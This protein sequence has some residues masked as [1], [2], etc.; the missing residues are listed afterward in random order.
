MRMKKGVLAVFLAAIFFNSTSIKAQ[1][2]IRAMS[3]NTLDFPGVASS[4]ADTLKKIIDYVLPDI[5]MAC[6]IQSQTGVNLIMSNALNTSG[7]NYYAQAPFINGPDTDNML[8]Y[9]S[10]KLGLKSNHRIATSLRDINEYVLY[11][12][13][14]DIATTNDTIFFY[15]YVAHLKASTGYETER[16][17]ETQYF[18]NYFNTRTNAENAML[19]GDFNLYTDTEPAVNTI[20]NGGAMVL[21]D[22]L[23]KLGSWHNNSLYTHEHTQSTRVSSGFGGGSTGGLD[24][25]FD[26]IFI[27][28]DLKTG[29]KRAQYITGTYHAL[30]QDGNHFNQDVNAYTN[31]A[32]PQSIANALFYMSDHLPIVMDIAV[33]GTVNVQEYTEFVDSYNYNNET[34]S[35]N[36][37]LSEVQKEVELFV[38]DLSGKLVYSKTFYSTQQINDFLPELNQGMYVVNLHSGGKSTS[39][40]F[41]KL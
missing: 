1:D 17:M 24:D 38:Y 16:N 4:R 40:K 29:A 14:P 10:N 37:G 6:E 31:T 28:N 30:G 20:M 27:N 13:S 36:I 19:G 18:R 5:F 11:Y 22:P 21:N 8:F 32:V 3:Y 26:F 41:M 23:N 25:R 2:T 34:N 15:C 35:I 7:R 9:N 12:K 33:G 39:M